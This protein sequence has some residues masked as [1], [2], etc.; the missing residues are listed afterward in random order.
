[1][2]WEG[3]TKVSTERT[4]W[5]HPSTQSVESLFKVLL[6]TADAAFW[7]QPDGRMQKRWFG[8]T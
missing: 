7:R 5:P 1:M 4:G 3:L 6:I 2:W 8:A